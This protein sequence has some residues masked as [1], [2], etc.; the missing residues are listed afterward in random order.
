[1]NSVKFRV[2]LFLIIIPALLFITAC[3]NENAASERSGFFFDTAV[4]IRLTAQNRKAAE[5]LLDGCFSLCSRME[6]TFSARNE[7]SELY[8]VNHRDENR[9]IV[10]DDLRDCIKTALF[11]SE[12]SGGRFDLTVFPV[13]SLWD[14]HAEKPEVPDD[15]LIKEAVRKV[16]YRKVHLEGNELTFDSDLT[17]IDLG[18]V[19]KG[20]ISAKLKRYLEDSGCRSALINLGGN[21]S[22]LGRKTSDRSWS[23]GIQKPFS[24]RGEILTALSAE[25][26]C[27][28]SSGVYERCFEANGKRYHHILDPE[29]GYPVE[30][31]LVQITVIG[32]DDALCDALAT[33]F[34]LCGLEE[35][36]KMID[37]YLPDQN[38]IQV[39]YVGK[40]GILKN[41]SGDP[42]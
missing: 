35:T 25:D 36:K 38:A 30:T 14:F 10:S 31:D 15:A 22:A 26:N 16:D 18:A 2:N 12:I 37:A 42:V 5:E 9:L 34:F 19:A 23:V 27:V 21:V 13:S 20:F 3:G 41:L 28:I 40:D 32:T 11:F 39:M 17:M 8:R 33:T 7:N 1:M 4:D 6:L 24:G 29:T